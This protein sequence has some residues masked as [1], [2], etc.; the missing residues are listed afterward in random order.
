MRVTL[1]IAHVI[2]SAII[3]RERQLPAPGNI[4]VRV[5]KRVKPSDVVAEAE[6]GNRYAF[7]DIA[8]GLRIPQDRVPEVLVREVGDRVDPGD[9]IAG[10]VGLA[11]R[12]VRAPAAGRIVHLDHGRALIQLRGKQIQLL[13]GFSGSVASSD[14]SQ[15]VTVET[16]GALVQGIWGNGKQGFGVMNLVGEGPGGRLQTDL[17]DIDLRAAVLVAGFCDHPAPLHQATELKARGLVV[18][19]LSSDLIPVVRR[20][21]YPVVVLEGF[22]AIAL[23]SR[24]FDLL[25][26]NVGKEVAIDGRP[27]QPYSRHRPE[28]IVPDPL[29][30]EAEL[31]QEIMPLME[32]VTVRALRRPYLGRVGLVRELQPYGTVFPSGIIARCA[33]VDLQGIGVREIPLVNLEIII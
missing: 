22:G 6:I 30:L 2:P 9:V 17:L 1:P 3:R 21:P 31:L 26:E 24:A 33:K 15:R 29:G 27:H 5:N 23:D 14:G 18:G 4:T 11:R 20:L 25:S 16:Q 32:G 28:I 13:A 8:R 10:P 7:V 12:T 19:G